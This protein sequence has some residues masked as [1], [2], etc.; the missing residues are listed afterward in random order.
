[1]RVLF[2]TDGSTQAELAAELIA[3]IEWP[4]GTVVRIVSAI[5]T[6]AVF[7]GAPWAPAVPASMDAA[8][9]RLTNDSQRAVNEASQRLAH[10]GIEVECWALKGRAATTPPS[11]IDPAQPTKAVDAKDLW[12]EGVAAALRVTGSDTGDGVL[13]RP[14]GRPRR[15]PSA[16]SIEWDER[17]NSI[18]PRLSRDQTA[19]AAGCR[20]RQ[21]R[22]SAH[23]PCIQ[24][25]PSPVPWSIRA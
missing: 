9:D 10:A 2:A 5:D 25:P 15:S 6:G 18:F 12:R 4:R 22:R 24:A 20:R 23:P 14:T 8:E 13:S 3:A 1:M 21:A 16:R 19:M 17:A 11:S 7:F